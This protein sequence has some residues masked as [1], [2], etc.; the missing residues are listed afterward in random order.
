[1]KIRRHTEMKF[2][3]AEGPLWDP[4]EQV[5]FWVDILGKRICRS[6]ADGGDL[7]SWP[8]PEH[9]G[10]MALR[11]NGGAMLALRTGFHSFDFDTGKCHPI[12]DPESAIE[13]TRFNDGKT[14]RRGRFVAG[15]MDYQESDPVGAFYSLSPD[16]SCATLGSGVVIF[17]A[18]CWSPDDRIFYH[19]DSA[20]GTIYASDYDLDAG[21]ISNTRILVGPGEAPGAPD[22][23]TVD[24]EGYIW[25]ARWGAGCVVRFTPDGRIDRTVEIPAD[26]TTSCAFGGPSLDRLYVT[27]MV[28]PANPND[29]NDPEAGSLYVVTGLDVKGL[30]EPRFAG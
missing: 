4:Q 22:G 25:S 28:D 7:S 5:L 20:K 2:E 18:P 29:P 13:R 21:A 11:K 10:A 8:V 27:S 26:K 19:A 6:N 1:M 15:S 17:N 24:A 3:L 16:M 12:L 23:A 9:I 14:D 30:P